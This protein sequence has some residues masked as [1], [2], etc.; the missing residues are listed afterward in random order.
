MKVRNDMKNNRLFNS[1]VQRYR[2]KSKI[3]FLVMSVLSF[4]FICVVGFIASGLEEGFTFNT[5]FMTFVLYLIFELF[6]FLVML[7]RIIVP[8]RVLEM[9]VQEK[10]EIGTDEDTIY[11]IR[12]YKKWYRV[13]DWDT[14]L[15]I[16]EG[17]VYYFLCRGKKIVDIISKES[18][19]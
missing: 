3:N 16:Q 12:E 15:R 6:Y 7:Y 18:F 8:C 9:E 14:F 17:N 13:E 1:T 2:K 5:F 4:F 11:K 10:K 19:Y